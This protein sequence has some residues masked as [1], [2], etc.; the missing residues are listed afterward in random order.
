MYHPNVNSSR[1]LDH[2]LS[3]AQFELKPFSLSFLTNAV[4]TLPLYDT[5]IFRR[6]YIIQKKKKKKEKQYS[7]SFFLDIRAVVSVP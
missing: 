2:S 3:S 5:Y 7:D 1:H 4:N 6:L